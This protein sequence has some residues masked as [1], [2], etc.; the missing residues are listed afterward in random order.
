MN[1]KNTLLLL[2]IA[3]TAFAQ[4][5]DRKEYDFSTVDIEKIETDL[6]RKQLDSI[7][8]TSGMDSLAQLLD[9][10]R[11]ETYSEKYVSFFIGYQS[12]RA[13]LNSL[14]SGLAAFGF[15]KLS[16]NFGGVPWGFDVRGKRFLFTYWF[17]PGIKNQASDGD[18]TVEVKGTN[19]Q[20][21][22]GYDI[23][24]LKRLQL[25][26]QVAFGLQDFDIEVKINRAPDYIRT[27]NDL[28]LNAA[29]TS[30]KKNS[31]DMS[32]GLE[33]DYHL[34]YSKSK[35]GII[36]GLRYGRV[37]TLADGKFKMANE[38]QS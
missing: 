25:Y 10:K 2:F 36:V 27:V 16:E 15:D 13:S 38:T 7:Y 14:N 33:L 8:R 1:F 30:L 24:N 20:L 31:F 18:Y 4:E 11:S 19:F 35:G 29:G 22:L 12:T 32:Y 5:P 3:G 6:V 17:A 34:L 37:V 23:L 9:F 21:G 28:I 26:P